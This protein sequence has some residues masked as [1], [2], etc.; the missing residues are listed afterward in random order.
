MK[1]CFS[2]PCGWPPVPRSPARPWLKGTVRLMTLHCGPLFTQG[3]GTSTAVCSQAPA[4]THP[5]GEELMV[6]L[7]KS[8]S[9]G[10]LSYHS[11]QKNDVISLI[12]E[13][14]THLHNDDSVR[15]GASVFISQEILW[16]LQM[17]QKTIL[18]ILTIL[19]FATEFTFLFT[20][21]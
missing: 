7:W 18:C 12:Y 9:G 17:Q 13:H 3:P 2:D 8:F 10:L 19:C 6:A 21:L 5:A 14:V 11:F 15:P 20:R 16:I 4:Q 1:G